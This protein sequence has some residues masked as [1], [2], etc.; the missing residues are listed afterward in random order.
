[1]YCNIVHNKKRKKKAFH[2]TNSGEEDSVLGTAWNSTTDT[3]SLK[4][5]SDLLKLSATD[6][7][8]IEEIKLTKRM[9]LRNIA[10][11]YD[12]IGLAAALTIRAKIGMQELLRM[13]F[14]WDDELPL[15]VKTKWVQLLDEIQE[16]GNVTFAS[17][18]MRQPKPLDVAHT[19]GRRIQTALMRLT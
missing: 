16:L 19:S 2:T 12:P 8:R 6:H 10:T 17:S 9:L 3:I 15:E 5:R 11:I 13:G 4:V 14:D 18:Q 7:Q 1:M